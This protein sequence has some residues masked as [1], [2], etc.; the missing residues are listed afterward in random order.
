MS[1]E[2]WRS[3]EVCRSRYDLDVGKR[4]AKKILKG[5]FD[6]DRRFL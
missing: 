1:D 5:P 3:E 6:E 4:K 2:D